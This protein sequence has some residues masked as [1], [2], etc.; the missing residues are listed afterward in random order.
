MART[1]RGC[2]T[3]RSQPEGTEEPETNPTVPQQPKQPNAT[4]SKV[5]VHYGL[6]IYYEGSKPENE[7]DAQEEK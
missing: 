3:A 7:P 4:E 6:G 1:M 2:P 5:I